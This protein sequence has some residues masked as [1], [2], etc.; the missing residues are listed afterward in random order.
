V[1]ITA[2]SPDGARIVTAS[3]DGTAQV[4]PVDGA[5]LMSFLWS[6]TSTCLPPKERARL[7]GD[8]DAAARWGHEG[9][10]ARARSGQGAAG[11]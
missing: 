1:H 10:L 7:F 2:W 4:F 6:A 11:P 3:D 8:D 9:C 5:R